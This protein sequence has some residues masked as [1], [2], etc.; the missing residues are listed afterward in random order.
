MRSEVYFYED[1]KDI[2]K[3]YQYDCENSEFY[4]YRNPYTGKVIHIAKEPPVYV[5]AIPI[6]DNVTNGEVIK[7]LF[8]NLK[9]TK[10][11]TNGVYECHIDHKQH[12]FDYSWWNAPYKGVT[13]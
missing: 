10:I 4:E 5:K 13:E 12:S 1:E 8:P 9:H 2:P 3:G 11:I 6:P 7:M